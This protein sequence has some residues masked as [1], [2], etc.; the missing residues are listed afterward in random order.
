MSPRPKSGPARAHWIQVHSHIRRIICTHFVG[1]NINP[2]TEDC[3]PPTGTVCFVNWSG[4]TA[5]DGSQP[6]FNEVTG[7]WNVPEMDGSNSPPDS[8]YAIWVGLG[9]YYGGDNLWQAGTAWKPNQGYFAWIEGIS[10]NPLDSFGPVTI[11]PVHHNDPMTVTVSFYSGGTSYE[12]I[13][14]GTMY[15]GSAPPDFQSGNLTADWIDERPGCKQGF[16]QLA[17][18]QYS[19]WSD[20]DATPNRPGAESESIGS[21]THTRF[22]IGDNGIHTPRLAW[23]DYLGSNKGSGTDNFIDHW[24]GEGSLSPCS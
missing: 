21:F 23:A 7:S 20:A 13:D 18:F 4:Y 15:G 1:Q 6:G 16:Y 5:G 3:N 10:S 14:N 19:Q 8:Q 24:E 11:T 2:T 22:W 17:D 12:I 9:G